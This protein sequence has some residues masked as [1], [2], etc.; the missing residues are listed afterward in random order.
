M[1]KNLPQK[2]DLLSCARA[3]ALRPESPPL[4]SAW[5]ALQQEQLRA[6]TSLVVLCFIRQT[7]A[8][9]S[10]L[11]AVISHHRPHHIP[12][13]T[14]DQASSLVE[15]QEEDRGLAQAAV[16]IKALAP[17]LFCH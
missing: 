10:L 6:S 17:A 7:Q 11:T 15:S 13:T 2:R 8:S 3:R 12:G 14:G 9:S 16:K 5:F 1:Q 4:P